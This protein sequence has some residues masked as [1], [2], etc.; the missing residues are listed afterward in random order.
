MKQFQFRIPKLSILLLIVAIIFLCTGF[1]Q[2]RNADAEGTSL[3]QA[4]LAKEEDIRR[5]NA[6]YDAKIAADPVSMNEIE[7][8]AVENGGEYVIQYDLL[9]GP[10][11]EFRKES[12]G[13]SNPNGTDSEFDIYNYSAFCYILGY[14]DGNGEIQYITLRSLDEDLTSK[15]L[16]DKLYVLADTTPPE[17]ATVVEYIDQL[18]IGLPVLP[19]DGQSGLTYKSTYDLLLEIVPDA[20]CIHYLLC[21]PLKKI[22]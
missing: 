5:I 7:W 10:Y 14:A 22:I 13:L 17:E 11:A 3:T 15:Q 4:Q 8:E 9:L 2:Q 6:E 21:L 20:R 16:P 1:V 12:T 18:G 19:Q